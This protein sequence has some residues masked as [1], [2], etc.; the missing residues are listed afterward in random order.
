MSAPK[1]IKT[2]V[3]TSAL[4]NLPQDQQLEIRNFLVQRFPIHIVTC[5]SWTTAALC[6]AHED[7]ETIEQHTK[8]V[9]FL[10]D[11]IVHTATNHGGDLYSN[12]ESITLPHGCIILVMRLFHAL[13]PYFQATHFFLDKGHF[14]IEA[15]CIMESCTYTH[16]GDP[17]FVPSYKT[18]M[19]ESEE[20]DAEAFMDPEDRE[21]FRSRT[22]VWSQ[23]KLCELLLAPGFLTNNEEDFI[24]SIGF[25]N[26]HRRKIAGLSLDFLRSTA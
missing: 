26:V 25:I 18:F 19:C 3:I 15:R 1:R 11:L 14:G 6:Q 20:E 24:V 21:F 9:R 8:R 2:S 7:G 13:V 4:S 5:Q 23:E 10:L 12:P 16:N 22:H 17:I